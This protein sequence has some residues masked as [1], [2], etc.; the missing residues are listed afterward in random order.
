MINITLD[1]DDQDFFLYFAT[2]IFVITTIAYI[3]R[4]TPTPPIETAQNIT[5]LGLCSFTITFF[6]VE[7]LNMFLKAIHKFQERKEIT[8]NLENQKPSLQKLLDENPNL[9]ASEIVDI[10]LE[11][12]NAPKIRANLSVKNQ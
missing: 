2:S 5:T 9:T 11:K 4:G 12:V 3:I 6:F 10:L 8:N 7:T 1:P